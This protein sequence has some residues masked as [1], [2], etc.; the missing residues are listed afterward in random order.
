[1][2]LWV[3]NNH[4]IFYSLIDKVY[5]CL[6]PLFHPFSSMPLHKPGVGVIPTARVLGQQSTG[7]S[8]CQGTAVKT[9]VAEF[10]VL[11]GLHL[12]QG[13]L[14]QP[15]YGL[16]S[17][18]FLQ[19]HLWEFTYWHLPGIDARVRRPITG[20]DY[21]TLPAVNPG[22]PVLTKFTSVLWRGWCTQHRHPLRHVYIQT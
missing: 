10:T 14:P 18:N 9:P 2:V 5:P 16:T 11:T 22:K 1:M 8:Q 7:G 4:L 3:V 21:L 20:Y 13:Y 17:Y 19:P 12:I 15:L 6:W